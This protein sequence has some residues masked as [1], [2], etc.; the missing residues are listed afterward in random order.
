MRVLA[1]LRAFMRVYREAPTGP[2][3]ELHHPGLA[4]L[5][6]DRN[7]VA[8][9]VHRERTVGGPLDAQLRVL[10][11]LQHALR[12]HH[13]AVANFDLD[14][15]RLCKRRSEDCRGRREDGR[16]QQAPDQR[17]RTSWAAESFSTARIA[18]FGTEAS[19]PAAWYWL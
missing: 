9:E 17:P 6:R 12:A 11:R 18:F 5:H 10:R 19:K 3:I 15:L 1:A 7:V 2:G 14:R 4:G 16:R 13:R 8:L